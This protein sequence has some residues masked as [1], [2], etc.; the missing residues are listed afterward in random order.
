MDIRSLFYLCNDLN[1]YFC[2]KQVVIETE[3]DESLDKETSSSSPSS[4]S[5]PAISFGFYGLD[6]VSYL[7]SSEHLNIQFKSQTVQHCDQV[8]FNKA[9]YLILLRDVMKNLLFHF[10]REPILTNC[11]TVHFSNDTNTR[12]ILI[13]WGSEQ[14]T[15]D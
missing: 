6:S 12:N 3:L 15:I 9:L 13:L 7:A 14:S 11:I 5:S 1:Q 10:G 8:S 4:S 2:P